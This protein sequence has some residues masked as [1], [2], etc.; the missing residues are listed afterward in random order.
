MGDA[1]VSRVVA[2]P[3]LARLSCLLHAARH[4]GPICRHYSCLIDLA[5]ARL[6]R[7]GR[8]APPLAG[9]C[10]VTQLRPIAAFAF[11]ASAFILPAGAHA[12]ARILERLD[13]GLVAIPS[14]AGTFLSWRLLA[15]EY[16]T[17]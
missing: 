2:S 1:R 7:A 5:D 12:D 13:R 11:A 9:D 14:G 15:N 10:R 3:D 8:W 17:D 6:R 4:R 16:G